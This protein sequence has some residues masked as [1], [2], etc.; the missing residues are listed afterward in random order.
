MVT[1]LLN[2]AFAWIAEA[3][4][5]ILSTLWGLLA[6][7][8]FTTPDVSTLPQV[9][10][11]TGKAMVIVNACFILAIMTAGI[12]V[13]TNGTVQSRYGVGEL[14]PRLVIGWI[15][16]N[17]AV[18]LCQNVIQ[19]AN[20]FT[21]A[22]TGDGV[23]AQ[24]SLVRLAQVTFD[25]LNNPPSAVLAVIIGL[26][27]AVLT[28]MLLLTCIVRMGVLIVLVGVSPLALACHATPFTDGVAKLWWRS[29]LATVATVVL[30]ALA[31]HTALS[32]FLSPDANA[33]QLGLPHDATGTFNLFIVMCLLWAVVKIPGLMRRFVTGGGGRNPAGMLVRMVLI[34][35]L[36]SVL[37]LPIRRGGGAR[38]AAG[39]G[40]AG[41]GGR[42]GGGFGSGGSR[43]AGGG[44]TWMP[45][46]LGGRAGAGGAGGRLPSQ[47]GAGLGR[48]G[49]AWPT[50]RPVRPYTTQDIASGVDVAWRAVPKRPTP[51]S[52][53]VP[54]RSSRPPIRAAGV[55]PP[56]P[57]AGPRPVLPAGVN[58]ATAMPQTQ[59]VRQP[60]RPVPRRR[61]RSQ[62]HRPT[63]T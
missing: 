33:P 62:W 19:L 55:V 46:M 7:T 54:A 48:V 61:V 42:P 23:T 26:I 40:G 58:P 25:S 35:Q 13:M 36:T 28:G 51:A 39:V 43:G 24:G 11:V 22:L 57:P 29:I 2:G 37:R 30:Q 10:A 53:A 32:V 6:S 14:L 41:R 34:Q 45:F 4:Q 50:G 15:A 56:P 27:I 18:P 17:F 31:L 5:A 49:V 52:G 1:G 60:V 8:A 9:T 20:A 63:R 59:P 47:A 12:A 3:I 16:A 38:T 21:E 44:R